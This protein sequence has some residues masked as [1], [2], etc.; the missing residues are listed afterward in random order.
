MDTN[1]R[2][3]HR[4]TLNNNHVWI[5]TEGLAGTENQC[6]GVAN[7]LGL[8]YEVFRVSLRLPWRTLSPWLGFE[9]K[10]SFKN[11]P[12]PPWPKILISA[13]RKSVAASRYIKKLSPQTFTVHLQDPKISP[14]HFDLV[15][16]PRHDDLRGSNVIVTLANPN[17][18][19]DELLDRAKEEYTNTFFPLPYP[20]IGVLIGG[21]IRKS[22]PLS[23]NIE[24]LTQILR[25][26]SQ[27]YGLMIT[28]SRRTGEAI[29][30][31]IKESLELTTTQN[32]LFFYDAIRQKAWHSG[33]DV[34]I[35]NPYIGI[36]AW[37]DVVMATNDSTSMLS[38][39]VT[40]GKCTYTLPFVANSRKQQLLVNN[41]I[42]YG[43]IKSWNGHHE[44]WSYEPLHDATII[45]EEIRKRTK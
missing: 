35:N 23:Q 31:K 32:N 27:N 16:V 43:A 11:L 4:D 39:A 36:L 3:P 29:T 33:Q 20:R 5:I 2:S 45:A 26:L 1:L 37:S 19:N 25:H 8:P 22:S 40:A 21:A 38:E 18:I 41:L 28:T 13:G 10:Y 9:T 44:A 7:A 6:I 34:P 42:S 17:K 12:Q 15:A 14:S 30:D 24:K